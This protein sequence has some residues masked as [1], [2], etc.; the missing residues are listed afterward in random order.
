[1]LGGGLV[2]YSLGSMIQV[3]IV[4]NSVPNLVI[5]FLF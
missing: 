1:V 4:S 2:T 3:I 5:A